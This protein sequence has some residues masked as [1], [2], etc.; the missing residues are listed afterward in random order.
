MWWS[1]KGAREPSALLRGVTLS[2]FRLDRR[3]PHGPSILR[4]WPT[5]ALSSF[6]PRVFPAPARVLVLP[7]LIFRAPGI[8]QSSLEKNQ[9]KDSGSKHPPLGG[10]GGAGWLPP[11]G[12]FADLPAAASAA[13]PALR[14]GRAPASTRLAGLFTGRSCPFHCST[15]LRSGD[16][17]HSG[18]SISRRNAGAGDRSRFTGHRHKSCAVGVAVYPPAARAA[19]SLKPAPSRG[20]SV[21]R[22]G[23]TRP[24]PA[25]VV[26]S[27][28]AP[29][30]GFAVCRDG[31]K[32]PFMVGVA[33]LAQEPQVRGHE[34]APA[35][36][37][38]ARHCTV[39]L[40]DRC[41]SLRG[42][43]ERHTLRLE[44]AFSHFCETERALDDAWERGD[45]TKADFLRCRHSL[46]ELEEIFADLNELP[47]D[48][49][50]YHDWQFQQVAE[51]VAANRLQAPPA[52]GAEEC[53]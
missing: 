47:P 49:Y 19:A 38:T 6:R 43:I 9:G 23:V 1:H 50:P 25:A 11:L 48:A 22:H 33:P 4:L 28:P 41:E 20:F 36:R 18:P 13:S 52:P 3:R 30:R 8:L 40:D 46:W 34:E 27:N 2:P 24:S 32:R 21:L 45:I 12:R 35:D 5:V 44:L 16:I 26:S 17:L 10:C 53:R 31:N 39:G 42:E 14:A 51:V 29:S 7:R 15:H 37:A